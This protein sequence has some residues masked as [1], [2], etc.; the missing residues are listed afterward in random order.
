MVSQ[1]AKSVSIVD[2][3]KARK[4]QKEIK[5]QN[6]TLECFDLSVSEWRK[7]G[8]ISVKMDEKNFSTGGFRE[9]F[10]V[11]EVKSQK[12]W[13]IKKYLGHS[14]N[15]ISNVIGI[16]LEEHAKKQCQLHTVA[17]NISQ[18]LSKHAP[19]EFGVTFQHNK[20][21]FSMLERR[22]SHN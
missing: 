8:E 9:A 11:V 12:V 2:L 13:V 21:Y 3:I 16:S 19:E 18:R 4:V 7:F 17:R 6:L 14:K 5:V 20:V 22:T 10:K 1:F 15:T